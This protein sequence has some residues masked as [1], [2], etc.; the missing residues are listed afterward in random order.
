MIKFDKYN[1]VARIYP[2]IIVLI[3]FLLFTINCDIK[4]LLQTFD[5]ILKIKIIGNITITIVLLFLLSQINRFLGKYLFEKKTFNNEL[6]FPTTNFLLYSNSELSDT[7]KERIRQQIQSDFDIFLPSKESE[8]NNIDNAKKEIAEAIGLIRQK[9]KDGRL[10]LNHNIEYGF[11]RNLVGGS[12]IGFAMSLFDIFYF[13]D[14]NNVLFYISIALS[15]LFLS[16]FLLRKILM[17]NLGN[18]YAK[19]LFQEYLQL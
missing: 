3:P 8:K 1:R 7:Y 2:T 16:I 14:K 17:L 15:I 4:E 13:Y 18:Q 9:V 10:L 5:N 12:I 11:A 19:R 6:D